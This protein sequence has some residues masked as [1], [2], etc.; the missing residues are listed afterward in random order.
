MNIKDPNR[1]MLSFSILFFPSLSLSLAVFLLCEFTVRDRGSSPAALYGSGDID[2]LL[3][4]A[5]WLFAQLRCHLRYYVQ[6]SHT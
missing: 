4:P 3:L 2:R 1:L 5:L 6:C